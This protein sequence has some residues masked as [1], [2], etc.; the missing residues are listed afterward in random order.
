MGVGVG[1]TSGQFPDNMGGKPWQD[2]SVFAMNGKRLCFFNPFSFRRC[3]KLQSLIRRLLDRP[4]PL[5]QYVAREEGGS[6][7]GRQIRQ[8]VAYLLESL[9]PTTAARSYRLFTR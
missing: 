9:L 3:A 1:G 5:G 4:R 7:F 8:N 6:W 2:S